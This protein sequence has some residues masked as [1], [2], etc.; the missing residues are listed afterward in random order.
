MPRE[1]APK[2]ALPAEPL[3]GI[4]DLSHVSQTE[5]QFDRFLDE[6]CSRLGF[7]YAAYAGI[8]PLDRSVHGYVNYPATWQKHYHEAGLHRVDPTLQMARRSIA[9]V[10]WRRLRRHD[11]FRT[12]FSNAHDFG[13]GDLGLTIPVR[14]PYG[15]VGM[16]SVT[17]K[18][19]IAEWDDLVRRAIGDLQ[20]AAVRL[21]DAAM[22]SDALA[23]IL[24]RPMLSS[25][26]VEILQWVSAGKS[27]Q[28]VSDILGIAQRTVEVHLASARDKLGALNTPQAAARAVSLGLIYPI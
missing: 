20:S 15:D 28:D 3:T 16:L 11:N 23:G 24:R 1:P 6:V 10:D 14:G 17:R 2:P 7:D 21:H 19:A 27:Q 26:E 25:R 4:F 12:V 18:V 13:I 5:V 22:G 9:P 8:N